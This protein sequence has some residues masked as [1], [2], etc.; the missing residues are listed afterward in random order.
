MDIQTL[1]KFSDII[2]P[3]NKINEVIIDHN[4]LNTEVENLDFSVFTGAT[5]ST[6]GIKG[7]VPAPNIEDKD[8]Y[9]KGDGTWATI[10]ADGYAI[11]DIAYRPYL[12]TGW[13]K[14]NGATVNR[15]D[16]PTLVTFANEYSLWTK[17][18]STEPWKFGVGDGSTTMVLPDYRNRF[19]QGSDSVKLVAPGLPDATGTWDGVTTRSTV[20]TP[21]LTGV[22]KNI[23]NG[24]AARCSTGYNTDT[25]VQFKLSSANKIYGASATVQPPTLTLIPQIKY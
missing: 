3:I 8:K 10:S 17:N 14:A 12:R 1:T 23:G 25:K 5:D 18:P 21:T 7:M 4:D 20:S 6:I 19:I 16:Y 15:S 11:G 2:S 24:T 9:L 13:V 22:F